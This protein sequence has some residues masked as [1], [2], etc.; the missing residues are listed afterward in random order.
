M[1]PIYAFK[2]IHKSYWKSL[3]IV[4]VQKQ[5]KVR[6]LQNILQSIK[7]NFRI[8]FLNFIQGIVFGVVHCALNDEVSLKRKLQPR[9]DSI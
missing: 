4:V 5:G 7:E 1:I 9:D 2:E 3:C 6:L 8:F